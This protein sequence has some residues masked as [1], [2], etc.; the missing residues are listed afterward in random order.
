MIK[1]YTVLVDVFVFTASGE[2]IPVVVRGTEEGIPNCLHVPTLE[3]VLLSVP[4]M[5]VTM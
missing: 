2:A 3:T 4:H 1:S 5:N